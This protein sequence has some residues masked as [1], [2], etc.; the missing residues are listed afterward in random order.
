MDG[1]N[2]HVRGASGRK[3]WQENGK[4][5]VR[6]VWM[7]SWHAV[8]L[9]CFREGYILMAIYFFRSSEYV[10]FAEITHNIYI[11]NERK[12]LYGCN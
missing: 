4:V 9:K 12:H 5:A 6:R 7:A 10:I 2:C 1:T 3:E 8:C 11:T